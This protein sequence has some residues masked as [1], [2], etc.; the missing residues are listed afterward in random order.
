[1]QRILL[2]A[3][4]SAAVFVNGFQAQA[5]AHATLYATTSDDKL[6]WREAVTRPVPWQPLGSA[7][8]VVGLA[9]LR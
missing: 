9:A 8:S 1:M 6:W 2:T 5:Q 3:A 7:T 4:L